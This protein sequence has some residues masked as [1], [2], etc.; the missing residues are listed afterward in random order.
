MTGL[1]IVEYPVDGEGADPH[2]IAVGPDGA[3]RG[4]LESGALA[5]LAAR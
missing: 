5:R 1:S 3:L 4:A 2:G